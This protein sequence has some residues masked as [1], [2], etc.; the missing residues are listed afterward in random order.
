M[1]VHRDDGAVDAADVRLEVADRLG[2]GGRQRVADRVGD[3]HRPGARLDHPLDHL[4][5]EL[6]LG[7]GGVL[8]GELDVLE[9]L[10]RELHAVDRAA[11]NLVLRELQLEVAVDGRGGEEHV[12]A[13]ARRV[14]QRLPGRV[15]VSLVQRARLATIGPSI[16]PADRGDRLE[17]TRRRGGEPRL[18]HVDAQLP[19][20]P[21]HLELLPEVHRRAGR[22]LAVAQRGVEDDDPVGVSHGSAFSASRDGNL[23]NCAESA[24]AELFGAAGEAAARSWESVDMRSPGSCSLGPEEHRLSGGNLSGRGRRERSRRGS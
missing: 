24:A 8:G 18:D 21:R 11:D 17:V 2:V 16:S 4:G 12:A 14:L 1:A 22:L 23:G 9:A 10:A 3:V 5:E 19:E 7:A 6:E 15:D 13:A 20:R